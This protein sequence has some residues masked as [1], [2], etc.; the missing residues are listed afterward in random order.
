MVALGSLFSGR[1]RRGSFPKGCERFGLC[2]QNKVEAQ[3]EHSKR[4]RICVCVGFLKLG[5]P[6]F[7]GGPHNKDSSIL[8]SPYLGKLPCER[9]CLLF[10][11]SALPG[12]RDDQTSF[13]AVL[14]GIH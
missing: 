2:T 1:R 12:H 10:K 11:C 3:V 14:Y 9:R 7:G 6:F 13:F 8:E 5:V 4:T